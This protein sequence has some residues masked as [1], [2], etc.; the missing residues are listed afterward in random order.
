MDVVD[1]MTC[2]VAIW[3][4]RRDSTP[5][6]W[7]TKF[8]GAR[9]Q[10]YWAVK[11]RWMRRTHVSVKIIPARKTWTGSEFAKAGR[12]LRTGL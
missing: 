4:I 11:Q 7:S 6:T 12:Y 5:D 8:T 1:R 3:D 10:W 9:G 2:M